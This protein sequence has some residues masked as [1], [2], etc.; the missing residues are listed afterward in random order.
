[1][2]FFSI[3]FANKW[4]SFDWSGW[5]SPVSLWTTRVI[6]TPQ[7]LCLEIH[8]SGL[9]SNMDSI[10]WSP[11][12]GS[13]LTVS[14]VFFASFSKLFLSIEMNHWGV[15]VKISGVLCLQQWGYE[16]LYSSRLTREFV[17]FNFSIT[18]GS[19]FTA[20]KPF[21]KSISSLKSPKL[22]I[23][24][25]GLILFFLHIR[26]SSTP[27]AGAVCTHPVP[28]SVVTWSPWS[29]T[30]F[31]SKKGCRSW[32]SEINL[33]GTL[34]ISVPTFPHLSMHSS[35]ISEAITTCVSSTFINE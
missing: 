1:M 8:Q 6:G 15:E 2:P 34:D 20:G 3:S 7:F 17:S 4:N 16:W 19:A 9:S 30:D 12:E 5:I 21:K 14:I 25:I 22:F 10:L 27:W 18:N 24:F 11:H 32:I 31:L 28:A 26:W 35:I 33:P 23:A 29:N 13:Q